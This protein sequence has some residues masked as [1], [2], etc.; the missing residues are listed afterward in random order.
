[1]SNGASPDRG[2]VAPDHRITN[3]DAV[4]GVAVLGILLMNVVS[5]GLVDTAPYFNLDAAGP[6]SWLDWV[7]GGA[8][9]V[10]ADQKFM[11]LFSMLFG[12]GIVLF[13]DR[14]AAK[15]R[16]P[17]LLSLWRNFLLLLI[18]IAHTLIWE[19]DVLVVY[20]LCAPLLVAMRKLRPVTLLALGSA[21]F[22]SSALLALLAAGSVGSDGAGLGEFWFAGGG[23][24]SDEV[25][26]FLLSDFFLRA[27]GMMLIGV[28]LYR[29][30]VITGTRTPAFYRRLTVW[31]L[32]IGLPLSGVGLAFVASNDF[33]PSVALTGE[34]PNI[35]G[36]IPAALGY[37]GLISLWNKRSNGA[38]HRRVRAVG[39]M[40][41]TN[42][43]AQT[44]LGIAV[45]HSF[46]D[47]ADLSRTGL[48]LFVFGVWALQLWW[49]QWWLQ[50]FSYGPAE[51]LWRCGTYRQWQPMRRAAD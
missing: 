38:L 25:G 3:L 39:R 36:T 5:Y 42:Y 9:E 21:V 29:T 23:S 4:R 49:S 48:L 47:P 24:P 45:L 51:W 33:D 37:L 31:G 7:I 8:G 14:A 16:R 19:G 18:G 43:L 1:M 13:A 30:G 11:A 20:A 15:G 22:L 12:A 50:R 41:L 17:A 6:Q 26:L 27:L 44:I 40:A 46:F 10:L 28:A 35:L 34:V 2:P 32:A